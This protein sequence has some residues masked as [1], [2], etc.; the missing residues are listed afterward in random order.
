M[1]R[2]ASLASIVDFHLPGDL[3]GEHEPLAAAQPRFD[4]GEG[5]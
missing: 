5:R 4:A 1:K 3:A 2:G